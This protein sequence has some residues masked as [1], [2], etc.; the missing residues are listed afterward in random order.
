M[1]KKGMTDVI[2]L[3]NIYKRTVLKE[4]EFEDELISEQKWGAF[5]L[6]E[7]CGSCG[8]WFFPKLS[9]RQSADRVTGGAYAH[10]CPQ[11]ASDALGWS[12]EK[13]FMNARHEKNDRWLLTPKGSAA[14]AADPQTLAIID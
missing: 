11:C 10:Y 1:E 5:T 8:D 6:R 2:T 3:H 4:D 13:I 12:A 14:L 9:M 7:S